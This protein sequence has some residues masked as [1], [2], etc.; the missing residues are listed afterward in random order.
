MQKE[1]VISI[2]KGI[3]IILVVV[4]HSDSPIGPFIGL[5][6]MALFVFISGYCYKDKYSDRPIE[7]L[8]SKIKNLYIPYIIFYMVFIA[9]HNILFKINIYSSNELYS[10][11]MIYLYGISDF[12]KAIIKAI[13]F[14]GQEP[15]LGAMWFMCMLFI[16][17]V[18]FNIISYITDKYLN[19]IEYFRAIIIVVIFIIFNVATKIGINIPRIN[20]SMTMILIFY[21]GYI[22]KK[23]FGSY[24]NYLIVANKICPNY[25]IA[26]ICFILLMMNTLYGGIEVNSN[27]Y[28]SPDFFVF[29]SIIGINITLYLSYCI[30]LMNN[31]FNKIMEDV[32]DLSLWIMA[33]HFMAFKVIEIVKCLIF[34]YDIQVVS[35][36]P[37]SSGKNGWW[38]L[39]TLAGVI[40]PFLIGVIYQKSIIKLRKEK[41]DESFN[42]KQSRCI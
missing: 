13:L 28:L 39:Y 2:A 14:L 27:K 7:F 24:E 18:C 12:I 38:I 26:A 33:L 4:G 40:I 35:K 31:K 20:N 5:F 16:T 37:V 3:G 25:I 36:F 30:S 10:G 22:F 15:M 29:N 34:E 21:I 9:I 41:K 11:K 42:A 19:R 23:I 6:H 1:K 32:G 8:K 17:S